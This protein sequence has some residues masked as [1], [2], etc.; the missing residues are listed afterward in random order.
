MHGTEQG[1]HHTGGHAGL[2][3]EIARNTFLGTNRRNYDLRGVP[4]ELH[5]F[6][7]NIVRQSA[8]AAIRWYQHLGTPPWDYDVQLSPPSSP[9]W[10]ATKSRRTSSTAA[11]PRSILASAT[12]M[13][14]AGTTS[15]SQRVRR[16][17]LRRRPSGV[18]APELAHRGDGQSPCSAT[19]T[20]TSGPMSSSSRAAAG[21]F[22]RAAASNLEKI[23][24]RDGDIRDFAVADFNGDRRADIL[25][26]DG[27]HWWISFG[28]V[29][30]FAIFEMGQMSTRGIFASATSTTT[31]KR[32]CSY[33]SPGRGWPGMEAARGFPLC[34]RRC[35]A[36]RA[37]WWSPISTAMAGRT[38][39]MLAL[40]SG[41]FWLVSDK[42]TGEWSECERPRSGSATRPRRRLRRDARRRCARLESDPTRIN[43]ISRYRVLW[44]PN[45]WSPQPRSHALR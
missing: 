28:G 35:P 26:T 20:A 31:A 15:S 19:S 16:G 8:G 27:Q 17:S 2:D 12:S 43:E 40:G 3:V 39:G 14:T 13:A 42:G 30:P 23:N 5:R 22:R 34:V 25:H 44:R 18:I 45:R 29:A 11:I 24:D 4:C 1:S 38:S 32:T 6:N 33:P 10:S 41:W 21:W 37:T 9:P 7:S 36:P